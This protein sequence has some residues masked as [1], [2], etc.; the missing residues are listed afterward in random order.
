MNDLNS[1]LAA[2]KGEMMRPNVYE[3][4]S[5]DNNIRQVR[6]LPRSKSRLDDDY[7]IGT[8]YWHQNRDECDDHYE[9]PP[10]ISTWSPTKV[11]N[12][13]SNS[14]EALDQLPS[15]SVASLLKRFNQGSSSSLQTDR[16]SICTLNELATRPKPIK[17][18]EYV[19]P[20]PTPTSIKPMEEP[21]T[22]LKKVILEIKNV[23]SQE[24]IQVENAI[25]LIQRLKSDNGD[26]F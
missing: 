5:Y 13:A 1:F 3:D 10:P 24:A 11:E 2:K 19:A 7:S 8:A 18:D 25:H 12:W 6:E 26:W 4:H 21:P 23:Q 22:E 16:T 20:E 17:P 15:A 14:N 9:L